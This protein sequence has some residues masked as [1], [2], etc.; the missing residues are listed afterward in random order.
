M[1]EVSCNLVKQSE[2]T[3]CNTVCT[4]HC[5]TDQFLLGWVISCKKLNRNVAVWLND[6][7]LVS[8]N[9]VAL[10]QTQLVLGQVNHLGM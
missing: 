7:A 4:A 10:R 3:I 1:R 8:V 2:S 5:Q 6:N 9:V